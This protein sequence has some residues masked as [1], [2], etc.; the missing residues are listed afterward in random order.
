MTLQWGTPKYGGGRGE[1]MKGGGPQNEVCDPLQNKVALMEECGAKRDGFLG[2]KK[3]D[4]EVG[5]DCPPPLP[6]P[7]PH[8]CPITATPDL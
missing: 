5:T 1:G 7:Q 6:P 4:L 3:G 8:N 2:A